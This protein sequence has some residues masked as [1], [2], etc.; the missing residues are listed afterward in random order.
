MP[1]LAGAVPPFIDCVTV[2][3]DADPDGQRGALEL[4]ERL[5]KRGFEVF[6]E[7]AGQ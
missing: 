7:G 4:A 1:A 6:V 3:A 2:Y 5:D